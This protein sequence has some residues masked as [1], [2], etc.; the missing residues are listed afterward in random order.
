MAS[1]RQ[2]SGA[3]K[4]KSNMANYNILSI[5]PLSSEDN[6]FSSPEPP[7]PGVALTKAS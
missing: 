6:V 3:G 7:L 5:A 2:G 1:V 4:G